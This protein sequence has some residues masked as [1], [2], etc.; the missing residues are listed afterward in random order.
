[1][2]DHDQR[3]VP[4]ALDVL[5]QVEDLLLSGDVERG[6]RLVRDQQV[7]VARQGHRDRDP[8]PHPAG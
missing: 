4:F 5:E 2:A 7:R 3:H 8:L 1:M 6:G